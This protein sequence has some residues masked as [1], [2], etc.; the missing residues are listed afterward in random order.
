MNSTHQ[1]TFN[2]NRHRSLEGHY[3]LWLVL[4]SGSV[5]LGVLNYSVQVT[6]GQ[7]LRID[8]KGPN[9]ESPSL[10]PPISV[11]VGETT[12]V[13]VNSAG[14]EGNARSGIVSALSA[15]GRFVAFGSRAS[16]LV[17]DDSNGNLYFDTFVH[18]RQMEATTRVSVNS[19]G[20]EGN[21]GNCLVVAISADGRFVAFCSDASNLV[22]HDTNGADDIFV[23]DRQ[24][25]T[26]TRVSVD[27]GGQEGNAG[28]SSAPAL[29]ADGRF[30]AFASRASNLVPHDTNGVNDIF[31][32]DRQTGTTTR[33][34]VNSAGQE[35]SASDHGALAI[36]A[37]GLFVAFSSAASNL[38]PQD[39]NGAD[40]IFVHD[41]QTGTTT[42]VSVNSAGQEGNA[43]S[44]IVSALS[45][46]GRLVAFGSAASNLVPHDT[47]GADD[48]FVHDR[49][50]G[51]TTRVSVNSAGQ[52]GNAP[53]FGHPALSADGRFV[54]FSSAASNL[55][56]HDTNGDIDVFV[57]DRFPL[58]TSLKP[59]LT[60]P[61]PGSTV[62][63][64]DINFK[65][66]SGIGGW[67]TYRLKVGS[68]RGGHDLFDSGEITDL[69]ARVTLPNFGITLF[70]RLSYRKGSSEWQYTDYEYSTPVTQ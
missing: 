58:F 16:N 4:L 33:V 43:M 57:R 47:N 45:V 25:G 5:L 55:V 1:V 13:S 10:P 67:N 63:N 9:V 32:H 49:Q 6:L 14:Q 22:S 17:P 23:H 60:H 44:G 50:T 56:P 54:A 30:V 38:V 41:R 11:D 66:T 39:T 65:W 69:N 24:E 34:S 18:D 42:R 26:T 2:G 52:E 3:G 19:G 51:T 53:I 29:S 68:Y 27:S 64:Q 62:R 70:V 28:G 7:D 46:D 12:R 35:G 40:D 37:D 48:I 20:Q 15:D 8:E 31:V 36:S 59:N 21:A 61:V